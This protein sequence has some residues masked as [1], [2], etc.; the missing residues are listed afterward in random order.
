MATK[1]NGMSNDQGT[2]RIPVS[3]STNVTPKDSKKKRKGGPKVKS[4][5]LTCKYVIDLETHTTTTY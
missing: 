2:E 1:A 3:E 4:G 5:C